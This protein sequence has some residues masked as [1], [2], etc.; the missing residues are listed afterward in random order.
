MDAWDLECE[1]LSVRVLI[2]ECDSSRVD[3]L[4][5]GIP[6]TRPGEHCRYCESRPVCPEYDYAGRELASHV[7]TDDSASFLARVRTDLETADGR[8]RW[9]EFLER[10]PVMLGEIKR[11]VESVVPFTLPD[12]REVRKS[13][14]IKRKV[15]DANAVAAE[16]LRMGY[17][18]AAA[19][20]P[21]SRV[22]PSMPSNQRESR[23]R[24]DRR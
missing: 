21:P 23:G 2:T 12:G 6:D 13:G 4:A 3:Y 8:A 17:D 1:A 7:A 5:T 24:H 18:R 16:L 9:W 10:A 14:Q 11:A 20:S 15:T 19:G 22:R